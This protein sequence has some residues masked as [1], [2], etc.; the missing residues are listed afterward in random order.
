MTALATHPQ[1]RGF[2]PLAATV[3]LGGFALRLA[4]LQGMALFIDE[5]SHV[6][7]AHQVLAGDLFAGLEVQK[8]LYPLALAGFRPLGPEGP[9]IARV[10]SVLMATITAAAAIGLTRWLGRRIAVRANAAALTAGLIY[11]VLPLAVF[12]ERQALVDPMMAALLAVTLLVSAHFAARPRAWQAPILAAL[13]LAAYLTKALAL[14]WFSVPAAAALLLAPDARRR[15]AGLM[16]GIA[17]ALLALAGV[18]AVLEIAEIS[19]TRVRINHAASLSN[20]L[21]FSLGEPESRAL[22][23]QNARDL[24]APLLPYVGAA[25][26]ALGGIGLALAAVGRAWREV[27]VVAWPAIGLAAA[28]VVLH[29]LIGLKHLPPRYLLASAMPLAVL[30]ALALHLILGTLRGPAPAAASLLWAAV[31]ASVAGPALRFDLR[32]IRDPIHADYTEIDRRQYLHYYENDWDTNLITALLGQAWEQNGEATPVH[33]V[34]RF[35]NNDR[36]NA[37][38]GPRVATYNTLPANDAR[39]HT[40]IDG[41]LAAGEPVYAFGDAED[42]APLVTEDAA[43]LVPLGSERDLEW[44]RVEEV[45]GG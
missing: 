17:A 38:L 45:P 7:R 42:L 15:R 23:L 35:V 13:L 31:I 9:W 28:L 3:L 36:V 4:R 29:P 40:L 26:L 20:I 24:L 37:S 2:W 18:F 12:H 39:R 25:V 19:G 21:I 5:A 16:V 33:G 14:P 22:L 6:V 34:G 11:A 8:W 30:A 44:F 27:L 32:L 43:V 10:L 1:G 41:W